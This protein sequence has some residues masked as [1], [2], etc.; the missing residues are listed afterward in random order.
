[1]LLGLIFFEFWLDLLRS[2]PM[3]SFRVV[4]DLAI[5][6]GWCVTIYRRLLSDPL[7]IQNPLSMRIHLQYFRMKSAEWC[8]EVR[9]R[10]YV[11]ASVPVSLKHTNP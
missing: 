9:A 3:H 10:T 1:M 5:G 11:S 2:V 8:C 6:E 7:C 4:F